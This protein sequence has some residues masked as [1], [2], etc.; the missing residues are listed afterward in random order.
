MHE[1]HLDFETYYSTKTKFSLSSISTQDYVMDP[2]FEAIGVGIAID[3]AEPV[4]YAGAQI[5]PALQAIDWGNSILATWNCAF[6]ASIL[7]WVYGITPK[8]LACPM[9]MARSA[10]WGI[11]AGGVSLAKAAD[12]MRAAGID[13]PRKG[14]EVVLADGKRLA[15]FTPAELHAY[16][17]Y[18]RDDVRIARTAFRHL[19]QALPAQELRFQSLILKAF[20][21]PVLTI[22]TAMLREELVRVLGSKEVLLNA[23]QAQMA[24][25]TREELTTVLNSSAKFAA[26]LETFDVEVPMKNSKTAVEEDGITP[27]RTYAF[28]KTDEEFIALG[29]HEDER[30]QA[31]VA[32]RLGTKST[33]QESRINRM[34]EVAGR[35]PL[36]MAYNISG[37][38]THRLSAGGEKLNC[39]NMPSGRIKGQSTAMRRSLMAPPGYKVGAID[40]A[41]IELRVGA[42]ISHEQ[43]ALEI[44][45]TGGDPYSTMASFIYPG[46]DPMVIKKGA[47]AGQEVEAKQRQIGKAAELG[48]LLEGTP[49]LTDTRGW[50]PIEKVSCSDLLW[51][52]IEWVAHDGPVFKGF[53]EVITYA[54]LTATPDHKVWLK[55]TDGRPETAEF[56]EAAANGWDILD[57][58]ASRIPLGES[59]A[60]QYSFCSQTHREQPAQVRERRMRNMRS[61]VAG[62]VQ[63]AAKWLVQ[64]L[65]SLRARGRQQRDTE[66][67]AKASR[68]DEATLHK[69]TGQRVQELW[70]AW[71]GVWLRYLDGSGLMGTRYAGVYAGAQTYGVGQDGQQCRVHARE[72]PMGHKS[73][74]RQQYQGVASCSAV[75]QVS[76]GA[77]GHSL[78]GRNVTA[79]SSLDDRDRDTPTMGGAFVQAERPVWD[80]L[81]AGPRHRFAAAGLIVSNCQFGS[82]PAG[83]MNYCRTTAKV[84]VEEDFA[85]T[86]VRTWREARPHTVRMWRLLQDA[87]LEATNGA[88]TWVGGPSGRLLYIDGRREVLGQRVVG[89][90]LPD[91]MWINYANLRAEKGPKGWQLVFDI[92]KGRSLI[93]ERTHGSKIFEN[94]TQGTAFAAMKYQMN[95]L[96]RRYPVI[97]NVHDEGIFV[98]PQNGIDAAKQYAMDCF[99]SAPTWL[100][101]CPLGGE[102]GIADRY[103]D[104]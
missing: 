9:S 19:C 39:Q 102:V 24:V 49:V 16:G 73:A 79:P 91:G 29:E 27:K 44:F 50:V 63:H 34:L 47:K 95:M 64:R 21:E 15:D 90:Q 75:P 103:G 78:C 70:R 4:W 2:R 62:S 87:M 85:K 74:E 8:A 82:G 30:V 69:P 54:G 41:Q 32:A 65:Q 40:S 12:A 20:T 71:T 1:V 57:A 13:V 11:V 46:T 6:D 18:C 88:Q 7:A 3:D 56:G 77:P 76:A 83:F 92:S 101:G 52:G 86:I 55:P 80:I 67:A 81:N 43:T 72:H 26:L 31:L 66:M 36:P 23:V 59:G 98:L 5:V 96:D 61:G 28:A 84:K 97:G 33:I 68:G 58:G 35:G 60:A 100:K 42:Y 99:T 38:H 45:R 37:A 10:G 53:K 22:D 48:C 104:C 25:G 17:E 89:I 14:T 93:P 94:V 51:D